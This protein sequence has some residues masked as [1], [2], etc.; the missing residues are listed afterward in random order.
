MINNK[1]VGRAAAC[2]VLSVLAVPGISLGQEAPQGQVGTGVPEFTVREGYRVTLAADKLEECRFLE[3]DDKG[4]LYVSQPGKGQI[5]QLRDND[6]DG[7]YE[8]RATFVEGKKSAH[9]MFF[10]PKD[11]WLYFAQAGNASVSRAKD[12]DND[13]K[14]DKVEAVVAEGKLHGGKPG[15][16]PF[17]APLIME[18]GTLLVS[19]SDP[20]NMTPDL[21]SER[22]TIYRFDADGSNKR[23]FA[24]GIRNTEKLRYRPG[25]GDI[26]GFDHG[27]D[28]FGAKYG[29]V[30]GKEQPITDLNPPEELNLYTEGSF[31]GHPF[32]SGN[33]MVRPEYADRAD[34]HELAMKTTPPVWGLGA[35]WAVNGFTFLSKDYFPGHKGDLFAAAHGSWNS[36][37]RVGYRVERVMFDPMTNRPHGSW[38][39][40]STL[41]KDGKTVLARPVDCAEAPDGTVLF[42]SDSTKQ[43]FR[44]SKAK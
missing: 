33:R 24:T 25:T 12:E 22:K 4:N 44:I 18:D 15:G 6:K 23:V 3:F 21:E 9:G 29:D 17:P 19:V 8:T 13:G 43:I 10:N 41:S 14:A 30:A 5:V 7:V 2:V 39:I 28:N 32:L 42:S 1:F 35:H 38:M 37:K 26:Y 11:G 31:Y 20:S 40:V 36:V 34:I 16:H 27:S